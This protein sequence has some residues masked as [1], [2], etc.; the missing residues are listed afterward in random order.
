MAFDPTLATAFGFNEDDLA[1]NR[2]GRLSADQE[3]IRRNML[4][5]VKRRTPRVKVFL[6][7]VFAAALAL[8]AYGISVTP[9]GGVTAGIVVAVILGWIG[10][11]V[12]WGMGRNRRHQAALEST[13]VH[14]AEG[15]VSFSP[16]AFDE[17]VGGNT[18][19]LRVGDAKL[20]V[21]GD[22]MDAMTD[23]ARYRVYYMETGLGR[24][25]PSSLERVDT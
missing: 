9:D 13:T 19:T 24:S 3:I 14:A 18:Y 6:G 2:E 11:I 22:Q 16:V 8:V 4:S 21:F 20:V 12:M 17:G 15:E 7:V 10:A 5:Y 1:A 25:V 23:G